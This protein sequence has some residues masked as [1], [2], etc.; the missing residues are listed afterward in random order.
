MIRTSCR[1]R[2]TADDLAFLVDTL[3][4]R[5]GERSALTRLTSDPGALD[6]FLDDPRLFARLLEAPALLHVSP[7]FFYY[8]VVRRAFV[9]H[10]I[11]PRRV[12]DYVGALLSSHLRRRSDQPRGSGGVYLVDIVQAIAEARSERDAFALKAQVGN[13]AL[14]LTGVFP[15][16]V[17]HRHAHGRRPVGL[18]Y[19]E[20]MGRRYWRE[21]AD[22]PEALRHDLVDVL[23]YMAERFPDLRQA[24]NDLVDDHLS[25]RGGPE[26]VEQLLRQALFRIRN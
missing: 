7:W 2:L 6:D 5:G 17:H 24:L 15:D 23:A 21:A 26:T 13:V 10:G 19:Y 25:L 16:W 3:A 9:E 14:F 22:S 20:R 11:E 4:E 12:A 8:V 1:A 18:D